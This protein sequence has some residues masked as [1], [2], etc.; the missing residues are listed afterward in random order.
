MDADQAQADVDADSTSKDL[1]CHASSH[2]ILSHLKGL[3]SHTLDRLILNHHKDLKSHAL[4]LHTLDLPI[5]NHH[6]DLNFHASSLHTF[7]HPISSLQKS[8][9]FRALSHHT[10]IFLKSL[11]SVASANTQAIALDATRDIT[12]E[13]TTDKDADA[14][15]A[16][17]AG[18]ENF[19]TAA[20]MIDYYFNF[21]Y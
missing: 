20:D 6:K 14:E 8:Q 19:N 4:N 11:H 9:K 3:N 17:N 1:N 2:H 7:N 15:D 10:S 16:V 13:E 21:K 12:E 18:K 5:L